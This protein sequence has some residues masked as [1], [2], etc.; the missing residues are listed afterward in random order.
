[1]KKL[2]RHIKNKRKQL[3]FNALIKEGKVR[4]KS[5]MRTRVIHRSRF[6]C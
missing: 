6:I 2:K 1:M 5:K 3:I 4:L